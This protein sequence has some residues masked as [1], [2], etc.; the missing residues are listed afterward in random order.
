LLATAPASFSHCEIPCGIYD[1][2]A[3][4][5]QIEEHI[6]TIEKSMNV[7]VELSKEGEKNYN[8]LVRWVDNKETHAN[9]VQ[10][11]VCQYFMTQ[12]LKPAAVPDSPDHHRYVERLTL[13]HRMLI[14]AM[15]AKQTT[16]LEHVT[17]LRSLVEEFREVYLIPGKS[18]H[19]HH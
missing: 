7:I 4:L 6:T 10:D 1:D 8:Q 16:D 13:L 2:E 15:K 11:I 3:R 5:R 17:A 19:S 12:R 14:H 18:Q 9:G